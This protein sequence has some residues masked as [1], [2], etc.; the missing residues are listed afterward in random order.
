MNSRAIPGLLSPA[1]DAGRGRAGNASVLENGTST[2]CE[3]HRTVNTR[4]QR[5][6]KGSLEKRLLDLPNLEGGIEIDDPAA[7]AADDSERK[8]VLSPVERDDVA[9]PHFG[10]AH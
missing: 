8:D 7:L 5:G 10:D 4:P 9:I 6:G 2:L 3:S 1:R